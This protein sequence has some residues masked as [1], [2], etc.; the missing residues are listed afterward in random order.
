MLR[1]PILSSLQPGRAEALFT[2]RSEKENGFVMKKRNPIFA[3]LMATLALLPCLCP[4]AAEE[5]TDV[6]VAGSRT[7][8]LEQAQREVDDLISTYHNTYG[9]AFTQDDYIHIRDRALHSLATS[10]VMDN[11]V[12]ERGFDVFSQEEDEAL[13]QQAQEAYEQTLEYYSDDYKSLYAG[14][15][16]DDTAREMALY[17]MEKSGCTVESLYQTAKRYAGYDRLYAEATKDVSITD[18]AEVYAY[19]TQE[20]VEPDRKLFAENIDQYELYTSA[21]GQSVYYIP[22]GYRAVSRILLA[23]PEDIRSEISVCQAKQ[24]SI[25]A[26]LED[27]TKPE[28]ERRMLSSEAQRLQEQLLAIREKALPALQGVI[29]EI[30]AKMAAGEAFDSLIAAYGQDEEM[31]ACPDGY[32]VHEQ[33]IVY[34]TEFRDAAMALERIGDVSEPVLTDSGVHFIRYLS[35]VPEGAVELTP[36]AFAAMKE[37]AVEMKKEQAFQRAMDAWGE[38]YTVTVYPERIELPDAV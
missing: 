29:D 28:E 7:V 35:D 13:M 1:P 33:S 12:A 21:Y 38:K 5:T 32:M 34:E 30:Q 37:E 24:E 9:I 17:D 4:C 16:D 11:E 20:H 14:F 2:G 26:L 25:R 6:I 18:D 15:M 3:C 23:F 22:D 19:Y 31:L 36:E 10:C 8:S 27:E